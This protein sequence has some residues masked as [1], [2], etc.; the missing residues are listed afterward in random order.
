MFS[1]LALQRWLQVSLPLML[2]T[3]VATFGW[4]WYDGRKIKAKAEKL[5]KE[6][7]DIFRDEKGIKSW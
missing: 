3:L 4:V 7:P 1:G 5:E 2:V 6:F